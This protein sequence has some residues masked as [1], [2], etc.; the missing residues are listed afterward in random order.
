M[1]EYL[2]DIVHRAV[3]ERSLE[4]L[5]VYLD[6][7]DTVSE[8]EWHPWLQTSWSAP[9]LY[10]NTWGAIRYLGEHKWT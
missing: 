2:N 4:S 3:Q 5:Q 8:G 1:S 9:A 10:N 6:L 7:R